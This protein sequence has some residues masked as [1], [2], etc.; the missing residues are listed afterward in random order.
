M[1]KNIMRHIESNSDLIIDNGVSSLEKLNTFV[2]ER[3]ITIEEIAEY[4]EFGVAEVR[5][6]TG[7]VHI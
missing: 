5:Q 2:K 1:L 7:R 3:E 4:L 6:L